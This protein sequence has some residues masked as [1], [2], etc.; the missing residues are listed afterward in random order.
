MLNDK[1]TVTPKHEQAAD[2]VI[3]FMA[4]KLKPK[5]IIAIG[6]EVGSGKSTLAFAIA[7]KLK[8]QG[9]RSKI[10]DLDDFYKVSPLERK[11]WRRTNGIDSVG[12][13]EYDWGRIIHV[14]NDF[15]E[16]NIAVM[17]CVDLITDY[18]D[19]VKTNFNGVD[20]AIINGLYATK[21][22]Q[23]DLRVFIE[24]TYDETREAQLFGDKEEI[25][26]FR[27]KILERE[28]QM[29]QALKVGSDLFFDFDATLDKYHL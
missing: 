19:E 8:K 1:L 5:Y 28:H 23:A 27:K 16:N 13:N 6:G 2:V 24:L 3:E 10:M 7:H 29:V 18:V 14:I 25:T 15:Y 17:P 20:V 26:A 22:E 11:E 4:E 21:I 12:P 9:V